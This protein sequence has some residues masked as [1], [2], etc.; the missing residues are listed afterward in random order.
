[1][2]EKVTQRE[3]EVE[4]SQHLVYEIMMKEN[5]E[6]NKRMRS[7][8]KVVKGSSLPFQLSRQGTIRHYTSDSIKDTASDKWSIFVHE[9]K[10]HSG[11]HKHQGGLN[12]FVLKGSGYTTMDDVRYD[13]DA[14]DLI[15]LPVK[16]GGVVHQHFNKDN[17]PSRWLAFINNHIIEMMGRFVEQKEVSPY[18]QVA[19]GAPKP[20]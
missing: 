20:K 13:W 3:K 4:A 1:M 5:E 2:V 9:V 14:G 10:T 6:R 17:K 19:Q 16:K 12:I 15:C 7:G 8:R 18:W 11:K